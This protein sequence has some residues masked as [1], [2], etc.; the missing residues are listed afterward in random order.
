MP[1]HRIELVIPGDRSFSPILAHDSTF[2]AISLGIGGPY[3]G[4]FRTLRGMATDEEILRAYEAELSSER[5]PNR[6]FWIV[7]GLLLIACAFLVVEILVHRPL[8]DSIGHAQDSLRRAQAAA[9]ATRADTGG[10]AQADDVGL[11]RLLGD[12]T[13]LMGNE[14]S[15]TPDQVSVAASDRVWAAAVAARPGAC[16]Y[17]R[18]GVGIQPRYGA[19]SECTGHAALTAD[20]PRW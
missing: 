5:R 9:E 10:F 6:G 3:R 1:G 17:L 4:P 8:A 16:F 11:E 12:L 15:T 2:C 20:Q 18:L 7:A 13:F 14:V 19:G